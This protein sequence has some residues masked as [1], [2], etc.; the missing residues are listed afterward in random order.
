MPDLYIYIGRKIKELRLKYGGQGIRQEELAE[1]MDTT[2]NTISRWET[3]AY[4]PTAKDLHG[5]AKFFGTSISIF[6]P[7]TEDIRL[8]ALMSA[9]GNL[10]DEDIEDVTEYAQYRKARRR[11]KKSKKKTK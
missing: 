7:E 2:A 8:H 10:N 3:A 9:T 11:L 6:F 5:L 4:K 1:A